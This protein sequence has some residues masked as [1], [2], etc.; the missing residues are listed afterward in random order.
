M[1]NPNAPTQPPR[2]PEATTP[3]RAPYEAPRILS[4]EPL[5]ALAAACSAPPGSGLI[6]KGPNQGCNFISS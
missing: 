6:A 2:R 1:A 4:R 5:E 3:P